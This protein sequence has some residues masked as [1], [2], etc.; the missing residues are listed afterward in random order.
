[1]SN[2]KRDAAAESEST[3]F[4]DTMYVESVDLLKLYSRSSH[5]IRVAVR[6]VDKLKRPVDMADV[7]LMVRLPSGELFTVNESTEKDGVAFFE[8]SGLE[9]G[10]C[11]VGVSDVGHPY[12]KVNSE[13]LLTQWRSTK[14]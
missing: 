1:M 5:R 14:M 3:P 12:F 9:N 2:Q 11:E 13:D 4:K 6:I 10:R 8:L 7:N